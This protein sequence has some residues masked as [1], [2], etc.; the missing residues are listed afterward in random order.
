MGEVAIRAQGIGKSYTLGQREAYKTLRE[1]LRWAAAAPVRAVSRATN[2]RGTP[3][4]NARV[5]AFWALRDV[6]FDVEEGEVLGIIGSNGAGKSTLLK[7]LSRI[8]EPTEGRAEIYGRVGSL[9]E[10]GTGFHPELTGRENVYLNGQILGMK[11]KEIA[12][13]FDEI[14]E[15]AEVDLFL[16][17][18]VKRYSSGMYVRLAFAVAAHLE[19]EILLVDEVLA[20]GDAAFQK[21]CM[22]KMADVAGEGRTVFFVSHNMAAISRFSS[23]GVW[24]DKGQIRATGPAEQ[25]VAQYLESVTSTSDGT[26][27]ILF[28]EKPEARAHFSRFCTQDVKGERKTRFAHSDDVVTE[29]EYVVRQPIGGAHLSWMLERADGVQIIGSDDVDWLERDPIR[30]QGRYVAT[31]R[32]PGGILNAGLYRYRVSLYAP[33]GTHHDYQHGGFIEIFDDTE[34]GGIGTEDGVRNGVILQKLQWSDE[35]ID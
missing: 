10:V 23:R 18:P 26:G 9:L 4:A 3:G 7:I 16:D 15:F 11:R 14:A 32:F 2:R 25:I 34:Y 24:I 33:P 19:P 29:I 5:A 13:K 27:S 31:V 17:T 6:S 22:G 35:K 12:R 21:K 1:G 28:P 20:V 30:D 8:T